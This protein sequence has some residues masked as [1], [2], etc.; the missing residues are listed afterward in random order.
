MSQERGPWE[1]RFGTG[2]GASDAAGHGP[3]LI[4]LSRLGLMG[5]MATVLAHELSQPLTAIVSYLGAARRLLPSRPPDG[6]GAA[7]AAALDGAYDQ[8]SRAAKLVRHLRMFVSDAE[9]LR[10]PASIRGTIDDACA[11]A[12]IVARQAGVAIDLQI[13]ADATVTIDRIQIQQVVLNL[14]QN[15]IDALADAPQRTLSVSTAL[16]ARTVV[17]TVADSGPGLPAEMVGRLF[18]AFVTTKPDGMGIGLSICQ[19]IIAAHGGRLWLDPDA[20]QGATFRFELPL[21]GTVATRTA[22]AP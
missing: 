20:E 22:D 9:G 14:M 6:S 8:A 1:D 3:A 11:I 15:A 16:S 2:P 10:E 7:M 12:S 17:V 5:Q 21:A 4:H 18:Q 19:A 13:E